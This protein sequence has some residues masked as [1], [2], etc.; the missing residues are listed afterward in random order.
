MAQ[1]RVYAIGRDGHYSG[2]EHVECPSV[3]EAIQTA[4]QLANGR[5]VELWERNHFI[6]RISYDIL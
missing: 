4:E 3:Q 6:V 2:A 5:D 1:Y